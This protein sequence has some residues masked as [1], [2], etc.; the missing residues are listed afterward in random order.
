MGREGQRGLLKGLMDGCEEIKH[1]GR[2]GREG[3]GREKKGR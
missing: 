3:Q 1:G 2:K